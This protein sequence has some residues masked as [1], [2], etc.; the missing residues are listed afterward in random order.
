VLVASIGTVLTGFLLFTLVERPV[1]R[2][3]GRMRQISSRS[4]PGTPIAAAENP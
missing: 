2:A 4:G 1:T 3:I